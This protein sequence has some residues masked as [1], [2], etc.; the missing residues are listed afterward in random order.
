VVAKGC[1]E[2]VTAE[3]QEQ[4]AQR[5]DCWSSPSISFLCARLTAEVSV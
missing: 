1:F 4:V 5:V 3:R 2:I